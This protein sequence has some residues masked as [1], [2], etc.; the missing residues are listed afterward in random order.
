MT[1]IGWIGAGRMGAA[2][3]GRLL[4][5]GHPVLVWNRTRAKAEALVP[6]G[7]TVA[8][9]VADLGGCDVVFVMVS[10]SDDLR[11]VLRGLFS[12][13]HLPGTV[14]DCS[15]VSAEASAEARAESAKRGVRFV[16][17]PVSGNPH[18]VADGGACLVASGDR[19]SFDA[20]RELLDT[21]GRTAVYAGP[22]EVSRLVKLCHNLYLGMM[23]ESL[24]EVVTLAEKGGVDRA[25][26]LEF[27]NGTVLASDWVRN[28]T[29]DLVGQ[30]WRP[31][32]TTALLRKDFDLGLGAARAEEVPMPVAS[33]VH[34]IIQAAIGQGHRDDD[35]LSLYEVQ[36]ANAGL[37]DPR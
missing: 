26:F 22:G 2:M 33:L 15:T 16:A 20:V 37:R 27:L 6:R 12:G 4:D 34:Q 31:T 25:A 18:V 19:E 3:A 13:E 23:V 10:T 1:G 32:F 5:A 29:P 8:D 24:V 28:R 9:E 7:A 21:I 14:V 17:A 36:A 30:D 11:E 35:F